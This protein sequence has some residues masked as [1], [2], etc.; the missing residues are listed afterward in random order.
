MSTNRPP[1]VFDD[2]IKEYLAQRA[3]LFDPS[4][5][6]RFD[7][8]SS[9]VT[10]FA[11]TDARPS[12]QPRDVLGYSLLR[13]QDSP[14]GWIAQCTDAHAKLL[15]S[16]V[17]LAALSRATTRVGIG[18]PFRAHSSLADS[19]V[20]QTGFGTGGMWVCGWLGGVGRSELMQPSLTD[21]VSPF[22]IGVP[23]SCWK[24]G[25]RMLLRW[26]YFSVC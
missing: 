5:A 6:S 15:T 10:S 22:K 20:I 23:V 7:H 18:R 12:G 4:T 24:R 25:T 11:D 13:R 17:M 3:K 14:C 2:H 21:V 16:G 19:D 26:L 1:S 8:V 9:G